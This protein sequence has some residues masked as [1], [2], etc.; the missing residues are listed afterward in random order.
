MIER[1]FQSL[2]TGEREQTR[3]LVA[4]MK[5][6]GLVAEEI[7]NRVY[8]PTCDMLTQLHR[9]DQITPLA[10]RYATR[11]LRSLIDQAQSEYVQR[12]PRGRK[13]LMFCGLGEADEMAGQIVADL[14]EADGYELLFGGGGIANDEI[15]EEVGERRPDVLLLFAS[16]SRDAP[17]ISQLI[18]TL[19]EI[20]A[21]PN[22]QIVVAGGVFNRADGL[23]EEVG[24]D[25]CARD[26]YELLHRLDVR[27]SQYL[28]RP[29]K[30]TKTK[31][32]ATSPRRRRKNAA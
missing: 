13:V 7:T 2:I 4:E 5:E 3:E 27:S 19:R 31:T 1:L 6:A 30:K 20:G 15:L 22:M 26:P 9:A 18:G 8:W 16:G 14:V 32:K 17:T 29:K 21:C 23:A 28:P 12:E 25:F 11:L 10:H 24:A